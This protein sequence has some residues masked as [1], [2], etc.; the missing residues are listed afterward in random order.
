MIE[1]LDCK[2]ST[3]LIESQINQSSYQLHAIG[4]HYELRSNAC[5]RWS[6][7]RISSLDLALRLYEDWTT[8]ARSHAR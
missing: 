2:T 8:E 5:E 3:I 1:L 7:H 4:S 6:G